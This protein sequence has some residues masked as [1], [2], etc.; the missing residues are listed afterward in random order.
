MFDRCFHTIASACMLMFVVFVFAGGC[1]N[2]SGKSPLDPG[3]NDQ[4]P[5]LTPTGIGL[6][7]QSA[8]KFMLSWVPNVDPDLAGY[9]VY[10]YE[11]S[12]TR[13]SAYRCVTGTPLW[14]TTSFTYSGTD[15]TTYIFRVTAVDA[16]GNESAMSDPLTFSF[17]M[18]STVDPGTS[19][20]S[21]ATRGNG[22]DV[23]S[24]HGSLPNT[25]VDSRPG[26]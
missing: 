8:S 7:S 2:D 22:S 11:P 10:L 9:R 25:N 19:G 23:G 26:R 15:G 14:R 6:A 16:S 20:Q 17:T 3:T 24:T 18:E 12:P 4:A 21:N 5:P 1:S 13:S